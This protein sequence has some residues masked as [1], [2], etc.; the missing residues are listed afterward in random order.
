MDSNNKEMLLRDEA[1]EPTDAVLEQALGKELFGVYQELMSLAKN[2][3][4]LVPEW[5]FYKDGKAWLCKIVYKKKTIL[6]LSV[7]ENFI[8][9]GFY[10]TEKTRLGVLDLEI[11]PKLKDDFSDAK[12]IGKLLPLSVDIETKEHLEDLKAIIKYKKSLK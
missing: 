4:E 1:T 7:W 5:R 8:K 6:W 12:P 10:F 2:E 11:D 3:F 9:T